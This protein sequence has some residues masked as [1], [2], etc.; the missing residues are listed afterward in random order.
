[1][2]SRV[3]VA[4]DSSSCLPAELARSWRVG[5]APLQVIIDDEAFVEGEG[6]TPD[7]VVSAMVGGSRVSTSQPSPQALLDVAEW[8]KADGA[9]SLV[10]VS[11]SAK[12]SGTAETMEAVAERAPLA[13]TVVDS[14]TVAL[15]AGL[16]ALS[17][18]AVAAAGGAYDDVV[19]E[20]Q[21]AARSSMCL[22]TP[23][24]LEYLRRGGRVGPAVAAIG[25]ALG[26]KPELGII[27]GEVAPV[28][29]HR[30]SAK[31][32]AAMLDR[33]ASRATTMRHP[34][35]GIMTLPGDE[36]LVTRARQILST[37][38]DW[39]VVEAGLSAALAAHS[40]PGTLAVALVDVHADV[41]AQ[42]SA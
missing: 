4:T 23:E 19:A 41:A 13:V 33:I 30:S 26:V 22:F 17:A 10:F 12:I 20:A 31:A 5:V 18:S 39:P 3:A 37:R 40:G 14:A 15:A 8:A 6:V 7:A 11:L 27:D 42:L 35:I 2:T 1:M 16:A 9:E 29:R 21:R 28:S 32:H 38:G 24:T 34:V 25:K 36:A